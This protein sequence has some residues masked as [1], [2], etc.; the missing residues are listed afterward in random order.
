[1]YFLNLD[2]EKLDKNL[3]EIDAKF[4]D[5]KYY[6][7]GFSTVSPIKVTAK[8]INRNQKHYYHQSV[9]FSKASDKQQILSSNLI[10]DPIKPILK[11]SLPPEFKNNNLAHQNLLQLD[12]NI[13]ESY[14]TE[15]QNPLIL[16]EN[17]DPTK[18]KDIITQII[19][20]FYK[21]HQNNENTNLMSYQEKSQKNT[22][23]ENKNSFCIKTVEIQE[24][25]RN[26]T[27]ICS[28]FDNMRKNTIF[29]TIDQQNKGKHKRQITV[30]SIIL[31]E[32]K[33]NEK[34][35]HK[36]TGSDYF[37][38]KRNTIVNNRQSNDIYNLNIK[39]KPNKSQLQEYINENRISINPKYS[40][41]N[42]NY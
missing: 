9:D 17:T 35:K 34:A 12:E 31:N 7:I 13:K 22:R 32:G 42:I 20:K 39:Y 29:K 11:N 10:S 4:P 8:L 2:S 18:T 33:C 26:S 40:Q 23:N 15:G 19:D 6:L 16:K 24:N 37:N 36:K 14:K 28:A 25:A 30:T 1:M 21:K 27:K 41:Y 3:T 5:P 38:G